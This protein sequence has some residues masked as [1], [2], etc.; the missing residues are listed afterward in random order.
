MISTRTLPQPARERWQRVKEVLAGVRQLD[1]GERESFLAEACQGDQELRREVE[2]LLGYEDVK[3]GILE[4]PILLRHSRRIGPYRIE[5]KLGEGGMGTVALAVRED[6]FRKKVALK[7]LKREMLSEEVLSRFHLERQILASLD[8]PNIATIHDGG[9]TE[10]GLPYFAMEYVEGEPIDRYC[11]TRQLPIR[12]RLELFRQVCSAVQVAHQNLVV[13]RDIKP[14][15]ILVTAEGVPK[16]LDFG[17]AKPLSSD[18]APEGLTTAP[19]SSPMTIKFASPEQ[20]RGGQ[21]TTA[22]DIYSLG[23]LLFKLLTGEYPYPL[24][25]PRVAELARVIWERQPEKPS[26]VIRHLEGGSRSGDLRRLRRRLAGDL[27]SIVLKALHKQRRNRYSSVEQFSEDIRRHL[28]G[29][30]VIAREGTVLY[31]AEKYFRRNWRRLAAAAI[32]LL[33]AGATTLRIVQTERAAQVAGVL[34]RASDAQA[35]LRLELLRNLFTMSDLQQAES[36]PVRELLD[37]GQARIRRNLK[38]EPLASQLESLGRLYGELGLSGEARKLLEDCLELRRGLYQGDHLLLAV[39]LND[40]AAWHY[41]AGGF[42]RA[43]ELYGEA[44]AMKE[45]LG[46]EG[47]DLVPAMSNQAS[48]L[49]NR[50]ECREAEELYQRALEIREEILGPEH[51]DVA[52]SLR[53]LGTLFYVAGEPERAEPLLRR[54]LDIRLRAFGPDDRRVASAQSTL[55]RALQAQGRLQEA[56][57]LLSAV[58]ALRRQRLGEDHLHVALT[59]K[60]LAALRLDQGQIAAAELLLTEALKVLREKKPEDAWEVADAEGLWGVFLTARGHY[61]EAEPFLKKSYSSLKGSRGEH[62]IY[63]H[64]AHRRLVGL[65]AAWGKPLPAGTPLE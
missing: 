41:R 10:D 33:A 11:D 20:V 47:L 32:L 54:A 38:G 17:I 64:N 13:H 58:L 49:M 45:R 56:E 31:R 52:K 8:H 4:G 25:S 39:A 40:L 37:R 29:L 1:P 44:L 35:E 22:T 28:A 55:G 3:I 36:F 12:Q 46:L 60:D 57:E 48:I 16:L 30:P 43:G 14:A 24:D 50:G 18:F 2:S 21:I 5:R 59:R 34:A 23:V 65:Y 6:D 26:T 7:L 53:A 27:D 42:D 61:E 19:G 51:P 9:T 62:S 63:T 15:N